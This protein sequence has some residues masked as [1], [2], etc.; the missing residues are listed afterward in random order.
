MAMSDQKPTRIG[1]VLN[2]RKP[3]LIPH[4]DNCNALSTSPSEKSR[5]FEREFPFSSMEEVK[6][7]HFTKVYFYHGRNKTKTAE[8]L[9]VTINT[10]YAW[11]KMWGLEQSNPERVNGI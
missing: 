5:P 8:T 11:V 9:K 10:V 7:I 1:D 4:F 6:R 2:I 3:A